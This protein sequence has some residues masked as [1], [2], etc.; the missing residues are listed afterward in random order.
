MTTSACLLPFAKA[1]PIPTDAAIRTLL[2]K[3]PEACP[4]SDCTG[5]GCRAVCREWAAMQWKCLQR[6]GSGKR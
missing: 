5:G 3:Q 4:R 2:A 1:L 6:R